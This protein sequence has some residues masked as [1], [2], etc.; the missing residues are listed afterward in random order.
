MF[1]SIAK[2]FDSEKAI[3]MELEKDL[4]GEE[5]DYHLDKID[6]EYICDLKDVTVTCVVVYMR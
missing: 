5:V 6:M 2:G 1:P 4:F 3:K